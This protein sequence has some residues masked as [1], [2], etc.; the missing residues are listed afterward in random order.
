MTTIINKLHFTLYPNFLNDE[1]KYIIL[2][3]NKDINLKFDYN[4]FDQEYYFIVIHLN[5]LEYSQL[6]C[7]NVLIIGKKFNHY[8][9]KIVNKAIINLCKKY[10]SDNIINYFG[11]DISL[12]KQNQWAFKSELNIYYPKIF[13]EP[14][15][16]IDPSIINYKNIEQMDKIKLNIIKRYCLDI[17]S[18][19]IIDLKI[20]K[21]NQDYNILINIMKNLLIWTNQNNLELKNQID[22]NNLNQYLKY[23]YLQVSSK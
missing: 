17:I 14:E 6:L 21:I 18:K 12:I 22:K 11:K 15:L 20:N 2:I 19:I 8:S 9:D 5:K 10:D 3:A 7:E 16:F 13:L 23:L 4:Y 1:K